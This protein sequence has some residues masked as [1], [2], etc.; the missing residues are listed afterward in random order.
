MMWKGEPASS[1]LE[2]TAV[3]LVPQVEFAGAVGAGV[4]DVDAEGQTLAV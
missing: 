1:C 2:V 4:A 3:L